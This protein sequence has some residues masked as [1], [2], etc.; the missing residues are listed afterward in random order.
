MRER[1]T[2]TLTSFTAPASRGEPFSFAS[3]D[4]LIFHYLHRFGV[5]RP[6]RKHPHCTLQLASSGAVTCRRPPAGRDRWAPAQV[7]GLLAA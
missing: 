6:E 1:L 7:S 2:A 4:N 3:Q 5:P